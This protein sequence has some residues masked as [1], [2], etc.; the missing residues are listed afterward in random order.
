MKIFISGS[1]TGTKFTKYKELAL[2]LKEKGHTVLVGD[3][4]GVDTKIQELC[5]EYDIKCIVYHIGYKPRNNAGFD[6]IQV[7]GNKYADK[8]VQMSKDCNAGIAI[9]NGVSKG[10]KNNIDRLKSMGKS[11]I[12]R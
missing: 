8:D 11:V 3:C 5:K 1:R 2:W 7:P 9:W 12:I 10:T 6:T 4:K